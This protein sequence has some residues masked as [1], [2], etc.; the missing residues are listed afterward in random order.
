VIDLYSQS[1]SL[2]RI[3]DYGLG[4]NTVPGVR[5]VFGIS[6]N[7]TGVKAII[8]L[9]ASRLDKAGI[10]LLGEF[11]GRFPAVRGNH[12]ETSPSIETQFT[13]ATAPGLNSQPAFLQTGEGIRLVPAFPYD[14]FRMNYL[15]NF[16]QFVTPST[17]RYTFRR[18]TADL[19]NQ[20][21]LYGIR[22]Q[23]AAGT[24]EAAPV[25]VTSS[26]GG[27]PP[28]STT[29]D[30][31]GSISGRLLIMTSAASAGAAV[32]FYFDPTLGG[33]D[34]NAQSMLP[35]YPDYRFRAPNVMLLRGSFEQALGKYPVGLFFAAEGGKVGL[36]RSEM[37]FSNLR[38]SYSAGLT[39]HAGGL[40]VVYVLFAWGGAEGHHTTFNLANG[41]LGDA[42]RPSLF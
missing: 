35:S 5:T 4:P 21:P 19:N 36:R 16:Q 11:N 3:Y 42:S 38:H 25:Y 6:E 2:N 33:S 12:N 15:L 26:L 23:A 30:Y 14:H 7:V 13:E 29:R 20:I 18:L 17:S 37:D 27:L 34:L 40:P 10:S 31:T 8:P 39:L 41:L 1:T 22:K 24:S 28:V 9:P 32:P